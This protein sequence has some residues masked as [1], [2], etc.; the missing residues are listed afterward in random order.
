M[1]IPLDMYAIFAYNEYMNSIQYTVRN[2]PEPVDRALRGMAADKRQSFNQ[3]VVEA[4][5]KATGVG[6]QPVAHSDLDW[7]IGTRKHPDAQFEAA[8]KWLDS[9]PK[10][11]PQ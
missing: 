4:L 11:L 3:T 6:T 9:V 1:S 8:Q 2:I 5:Q 10:D 7:F